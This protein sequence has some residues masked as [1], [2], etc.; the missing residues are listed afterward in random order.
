MAT[1][2]AF[3]LP[4][5]RPTHVMEIVSTC[6]LVLGMLQKVCLVKIADRLRMRCTGRG[7][8]GLPSCAGLPTLQTQPDR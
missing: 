2:S 1:I 7:E 6:G 4:A 5:V 3:T 8:C